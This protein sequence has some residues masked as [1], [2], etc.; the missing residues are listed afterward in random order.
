MSKIPEVRTEVNFVDY[1]DA[2]AAA[3]AVIEANRC[4][5]CEDAPCIQA[6]PTAIDIP[7]FIRKIATENVRGSA[8]TIFDSNILGMSCARV[9]PVEVLCVGSCVFNKLD[10]PPIQIG[11]L[12]RYATDLAYDK[13]WKFYEAG[14]DTGFS[15]AIVGAGPAGLAAA[16]DLRRFGHAVTMYEKRAVLGGLNST[17][18]A[19]YKMRADRAAAEVDWILD[20]GGIDVQTGVEVGEDVFWSELEAKHDAIFVAIGLGPDK[21]LKVPG[22]ELEG[23]HGAVDWIEQMKLGEVSLEGVERVVVVGGGNT[24]VDVVR[25][26]LQLG[27]RAVTML[28][29]GTEEAMSGYAHEWK[30]AK[31]E[32]ARA[33]WQ[34]LPVAYLGEDRVKGV[35]CVRMDDDKK[36]IE[37]SEVVVGADLVLLAIGQGKLGDMVSSLDGIAVEWGV[38]QTEESG[39]TGRAGYFAGGDCANGGKE[40]VNA[41]AEGK[42]AAK[43]IN[44]YLMQGTLTLPAE[45]F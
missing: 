38:M 33:L 34:G 17:G 13:G 4:L 10:V 2:Y 14:P 16:H 5:F 35:R 37:G 45:G 26:A 21:H 22:T 11:K 41:A 6:C 9:C 32:G 12:Q 27:V 39:A 30:A 19:P 40:V 18:V 44:G 20:I 15:V 25:E 29:R 23:V 36:P 7:Q 31:I 43:A 1:K 3:Q 28:Y 24:A 42:R 8:R